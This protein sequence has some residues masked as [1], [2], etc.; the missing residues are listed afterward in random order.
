MISSQKIKSIMLT[1]YIFMLLYAPPIIKN[2]NTLLIVFVFSFIML[3]TKYKKDTIKFFKEKEIK[4]IAFLFFFFF[5]L[6]G[7]SIII[8]YLIY[9]EIYFYNI[10]INLY[11]M[12]LVIP[13]TLLCV[14]FVL[15]YAKRNNIAFEKVIRLTIYAGT[16]QGVICL[17]S[18]LFP[19]FKSFLLS[20]LYYLTGDEL[21]VD[22]FHVP[23][24][25]YGYSNGMVDAFGF[26]SGIIAA[27]PLFY[28]LKNGKK[29]LA[30][31]PLLLLIVILNSRTGLV[32]FGI[33]IIIW[34]ICLICN[35][36]LK[37][38]KNVILCSSIILF[39]VLLVVYLVKP[40]TIQ[41]I[42]K[43]FSSF[44][45]KNWGTANVLF[46]SNFWRLPSLFRVIIGAGYSIAGFGGVSDILGFSSD[47]GYINEI[48]R[49]GL[50]GLTI[51]IFI[52]FYICYVI[53]KKQTSK[54]THL[55]I[56]FL[57]S[58]LVG[59]I[60]LVIFIYNPG[61]VV[62]LMYVLY[63][64]VPSLHIIK[65]EK[66]E[67]YSE[68]Q[69]DKI[70]VIVPI[71]NA[72]KYLKKCLDSIISQSY[73]NLEIILV[74]D[75]SKD[76]SLKIC[77]AYAAKDKRITIVDKE[78][79]GQ[80]SARNKG[81][82][83]ATGKYI[84]FVD[85]DDWIDLDTF[86]YL[87]YLVKKH[88]A[89]C[90][91]IKIRKNDYDFQTEHFNEKIYKGDAILVEYLKYGMKTGEYSPCTYLYSKKIVQHLKF[92]EGKINED[93]PFIYKAL[94]KANIL[95]KSNKYCYNYRLSQNS[96]TRNKFR[97]RDFDLFDACDDLADYSKNKSKEIQKLIK[98]KRDR[99]DF[100]LLAKIAYYG[101][102]NET[103]F[104]D[105]IQQMKKN[106][107]NNYLE[108]IFTNMSLIRK[109]QLTC[110]VINYDFTKKMINFIRKL[111][112]QSR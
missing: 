22:K 29:F 77:E 102:E 35:R 82:D 24:R 88:H 3:I 80:A 63:E 78:N 105:E 99:S 27:L 66:L 4:K 89:D 54:Y 93:I 47:V 40:L 17:L 52:L 32:I 94:D 42:I 104:Q 53:I 12:G 96:T 23:R 71:Y 51:M 10:F 46:S 37:E 97:K 101:A 19:S 8:N 92:P 6:Y 55:I 68:N 70:S 38:Y 36:K 30:F 100:S 73:T 43:D 72:E 21:F 98:E 64:L 87:H 81:L 59:N 56:F 91:F 41:W 95:V 13:I 83:I 34:F 110:F 1:I 90:S 11:S 106:I 15:I 5:F 31:I 85:S 16:I 25:F 61:I 33:G 26:G 9:D 108:L 18:F 111:K 45:T 69:K 74:N 48:W 112:G 103:E 62:I 44:F 50:I 58:L 107:R 39:L 2:V 14:L 67:I 60:K 84:G 75:G 7:I 76:E 86:D 65:K 20:L 28:S 79:G 109:I 49:T 57:I